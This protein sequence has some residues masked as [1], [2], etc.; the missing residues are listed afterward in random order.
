MSALVI[1][2][3]VYQLAI[4]FFGFKRN[5]KDYQ[6]HPPQQRF[7]V[8]VP[9]HNEE[10]VIADIINSLTH[11]EY[12]KELYDFYILADNCEDRTADVARQM[13]ANVLEISRESED[14][15]T[16]KPVVLQRA[17]R[18][19]EGYQDHYDMVMFFDA[20][21]LVDP[22]MLLEVNSQYL[23]HKGKA[24]II[25]CYLGSKNKKGIVARSYFMTFTI[26]NRFFQ[27]AKSH[28]GLNCGIGGTGF[29]VT[30]SYLHS[31]GGWTAMSLTE[32][33]ELQIEATCDGK[34]ILWNH[35]VRIYDEKPTKV[36]ASIRQR[37]RWAQGN[38]FVTF[39][40]TA[41][42]FRALKNKQVTAKEFVSTLLCMYSLTAYIFLVIQLI[43]GLILNVFEW[44]RLIAPM[45]TQIPLENWLTL[46]LPSLL[47]FLYSSL[48]LFYVGDHMDNGNRFTLR[49]L[50]PV[51]L[52]VLLNIFVITL[53][54]VVGL[55]RYRHQSDWYKTEHSINCL[56]ETN[57]LPRKTE[58]APPMATGSHD[59]TKENSLQRTVE[60][61]SLQLITGGTEKTA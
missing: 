34:R 20:D 8:L 14:A 11:M 42:L 1:L 60:E 5:T 16:G 25:Q 22:N 30:A 21:N 39:R 19:L 51:I 18:M 38:W 33:F 55:F 28:L 15:P 43:L 61:Q 29:A 9:A 56:S 36:M 12:P 37:T 45:D 6:D 31:R 40:N 27:Y 59:F 57:L 35:N 41:R 46:N 52:S 23:S 13:G 49:M 24:D 26:T 54:Q 50:V 48:V 17:L 44:T 4:G 7:L 47:L 53:A 3:L 32:D 2:M 10:T 58:K